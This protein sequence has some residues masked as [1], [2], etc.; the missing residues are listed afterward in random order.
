MGKRMGRSRWQACMNKERKN[1]RWLW[2]ES[3]ADHQQPPWMAVV[4]LLPHKTKIMEFTFNELQWWFLHF[5]VCLSF[6]KEIYLLAW[7]RQWGVGGVVFY[8][9]LH[10]TTTN[11]PETQG[12]QDAV[13]ESG[14]HYPVFLPTFLLQLPCD[15]FPF[16]AL[17][18]LEE[19]LYKAQVA[20]Y[21]I[22]YCCD[23]RER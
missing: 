11:D 15:L 3:G 6:S 12:G 22:M 10:F 18:P 17:I 13:L 8:L 14:P 19:R 23:L 1:R 20:H 21:L 4:F 7:Q 5:R 2:E 16:E 9:C